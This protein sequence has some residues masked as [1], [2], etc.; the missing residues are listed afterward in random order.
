MGSGWWWGLGPPG[1]PPS[2]YRDPSGI[3]RAILPSPPVLWDHWDVVGLGWLQ[4]AEPPWD[5]QYQQGPYWG[6]LGPAWTPPRGGQ[7]DSAPPVPW[8]HQ[9][10]VGSGC[11]TD[12]QDLRGPP[13]TCRASPSC[14]LPPSSPPSPWILGTGGQLVWGWQPQVSS[15]SWH[16]VSPRPPRLTSSKSS[17]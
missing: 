16:T 13:S 2:T 8:D 15:G 12:P 14:S 11:W 5:P 6:P 7:H 17:C 3:G 4:W 1:D 10:M 9:G